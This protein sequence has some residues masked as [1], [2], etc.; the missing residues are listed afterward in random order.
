MSFMDKFAVTFGSLVVDLPLMYLTGA[1]VEA[2]LAESTI[3]RAMQKS[4]DILINY[5]EMWHNKLLISSY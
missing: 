5:L 1:V 3:M 2:G 4:T